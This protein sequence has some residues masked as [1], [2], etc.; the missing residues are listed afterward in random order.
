MHS[1]MVYAAPGYLLFVQEGVLFA[2]RFDLSRLRLI[3]EPARVADGLAYFRTVGNGAFSISAT[4]VLAFQGAEA[5]ARIVAYDRRGVATDTGWAQQ[6]YG[7]IRFSRDGRRVAVDV[8]DPRFGTADVWVYDASRGAPIR[9]TSDLSDESAPVWSGDGLQ[10]LIRMSRG[11][12]DSLRLGSAAPN[13]Y[14]KTIATGAE[15]LLVRDSSALQTEDW[16]P[17]GR[18][19]AY[20]RNTRQTG[21]D[22]WLV[23]IRGSSPPQPFSNERFEEHGAVFSPDSRWLAFVSNE[24]GASEVYVAPVGGGARTRLSVGGGTSPRWNANGRELFYAA[25][26]NR[27]IMSV[28]VQATGGTITAALPV[29][30]FSIDPTPAAFSARRSMIYDVAPDGQR[31]LVS[32]PAG[33]AS[34]SRVTVV[35][36]WMSA[37]PN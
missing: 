30:L 26:S 28:A 9:L 23:A 22:I 14:A 4:G 20:T 2:Q 16:S 13:L 12:A 17:D 11:E 1:K 34:S 29:R 37:L 27:A 6:N 18:W 31:F 36:N 19:V 8:V 25:A 10:L 35:L 15:T 32:V 3:G 5:A 21:A 24:S 7:S 33:E